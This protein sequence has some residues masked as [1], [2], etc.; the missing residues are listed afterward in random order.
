[1][2][3]ALYI[4]WILLVVLISCKDD[5]PSLFEKTADERVA[6]AIAALKADLVAPTNGWKVKYKPE[7]EAGSF[8]VFMKFEEN[9]TVT[10]ETDLGSDDGA[11]YEQTITYRID[12]SLG[13]ELIFEN[14]SFFSFLFEQDQATFGA[15]YE[16]NYVNKTPDDALVFRSKTDAGNATILLLEEAAANERSTLL[17]IDLANNLNT[18]SA[19]IDRFTSSLKLTYDTR[20]LIFYLAL[21]EFKRTITITSASKK[22]NTQS[23]QDVDFTTGYLIQGDSIIFDATLSGSFAGTSVSIKS[24]KFNALADAT[25]DGLCTDPIPIHAYN[26]ITS[27]G[28]AVTLEPTMLDANGGGFA[29]L[30]DWYFSPLNFIFDNGQSASSDIQ[31]NIAGALEMHLLYGLTLGD[32]SQLFGIGFAV[33]N[34]DGTDTIILR[35]FTP[36]L[37]N[38]NLVFTFKSGFRLFGNPDPD[39][40]L[41]N[42]N[43]YLDQLTQGDKTFVF[44]YSD[45][46][47]EFYNPCTGW[48]FVFVDTNQ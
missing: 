23:T 21:D 22:S 1:M 15:E 46:L 35:E 37:N 20:D 19:D 4:V 48:S 2:K 18:L 47:Y 8:Y 34:A 39:A 28:H 44:E 27:A 36:S 10:I 31:Q 11:Y 38:N 9:N 33:R 5:D 41:D 7:P 42:I 12:N 43:I 16:F 25:I 13:L 3:R 26:G 45:G 29:E 14:Y 32:G 24:I 6:E 40:T 30:S 17:G